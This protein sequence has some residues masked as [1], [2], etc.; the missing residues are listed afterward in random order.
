MFLERIQPAED[1][2]KKRQLDSALHLAGGALTDTTIAA[3]QKAV[4]DTE[5]SQACLTQNVA[6]DL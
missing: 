6:D 3:K 4:S 2:Q 1:Q 5:E